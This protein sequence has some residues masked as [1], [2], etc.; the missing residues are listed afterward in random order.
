MHPWLFDEQR[1]KEPS[2]AAAALVYN[3]VDVIILLSL[4]SIS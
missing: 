1:E 3:N 2:A 4:L